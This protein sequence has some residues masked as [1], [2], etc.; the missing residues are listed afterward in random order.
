MIYIGIII[1]LGT[2]ALYL[3][4]PEHTRRLMIRWMKHWE[5]QQPTAKWRTEKWTDTYIRA[6]GCV[7]AIMA[8]VMLFIVLKMK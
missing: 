8:F 7:F 3:I 6:L 2:S 4:S 1:L 5:Y